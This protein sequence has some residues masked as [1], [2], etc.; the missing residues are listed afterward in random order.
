MSA[1]SRITVCHVLHT[2]HVGGAEILAAEYARRATPEFRVVFACL[3][4][5]GQMSDGLRNEGFAVHVVGRKAGFDLGCARRL[6]TILRRENVDLVHAHQ[7]G[8][9]FYASLSRLFRWGTPLL[10]MEHGRD[11]PD[12]PRPKRKL[13][14]RLLLRRGDRV[15]AVGQCVKRA[16]IDNEGLPSDRIEVIYNGVQLDRYDPRRPA[17][18]EV[19]IELGLGQDDIAFFQV[20]RLNRLKDHPTAIRAMQILGQRCPR[21]RLYLVGDGE[22]RFAV[23]RLISELRLEPFVRLLGTRRDVPRLLQ[24]ADAYLLS[25]VTE[26]ISLSLIEAMATALPIVAT[27]VGGNGEVVVAG[28][29]GY[30]A[31]AGDAAGLAAAMERLCVDPSLRTRLGIAGELRARALFDD[32]AMHDRYQAIYREMTV[33]RARPSNSPSRRPSQPESIQS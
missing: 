12:Y 9:F 33:G 3:D 17:R 4:E 8:P 20:A 15:A 14:N 28:E 10:F 30:L 27:D 25:S 13:A 2:M 11:Y 5:A 1:D 19:R 6:A 26:G 18:D 31:P 29:T 7:Y 32:N 16:L 22:E 23:E 24:A 21:V